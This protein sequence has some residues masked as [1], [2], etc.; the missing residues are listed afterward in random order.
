MENR[1]HAPYRTFPWNILGVPRWIMDRIKKYDPELYSRL[2][3]EHCNSF[4]YMDHK[5]T[6]PNVINESSYGAGYGAM[7]CLIENLFDKMNEDIR[8]YKKS[9]KMAHPKEL[10]HEYD[11]KC[12]CTNCVLRRTSDVA[13]TELWREVKRD[14]DTIDPDNKLWIDCHENEIDR[15]FSDYSCQCIVHVAYRAADKLWR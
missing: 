2:Y 15:E 5:G 3:S 10:G 11:G 7:D 14:I 9:L 13:A 4:R 12:S 8:D 1:S 6:T